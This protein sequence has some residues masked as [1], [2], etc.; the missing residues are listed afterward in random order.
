MIQVLNDREDLDILNIT[1]RCRECGSQWVVQLGRGLMA[2]DHMTQCYRCLSREA[3][4]SRQ[5]SDV[6]QER[7][8]RGDGK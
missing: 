4:E 2:P 5:A 3:S 7:Q 1:I 6:S 8:R